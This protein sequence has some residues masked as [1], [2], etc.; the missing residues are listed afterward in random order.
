[1]TPLQGFRLEAES[2]TRDLADAPEAEFSKASPCQPW[3][4]GDLLHHIRIGAGRLQE[5]LSQPEPPAESKLISAVDYYR[6]EKRF[7]HAVNEDRISAAQRGAAKLGSGKA[8]LH[9]FDRTWRVSY[10]LAKT[11][12]T[13]RVIRTRH[14]DPMLLTEFLRTRVLELAVHGLDL[15]AALQRTPWLT[16]EAAHIVEDLIFPGK[17]GQLRKITSWSNALLIAK[18]TGRVPLA[19]GERTLLERHN[20]RSLAL[21]T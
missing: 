16:E 2:L 17:A 21:G 7:T 10:D 15:A 19:D 6:P 1:M 5:L 9:D 3:T 20:F 18:A 12:P 8:V 14:G 11:A 4:V 13:T